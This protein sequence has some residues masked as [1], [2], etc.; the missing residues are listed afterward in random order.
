MRLISILL[1]LMTVCACDASDRKARGQAAWAWASVSAKATP[2]ETTKPALPKSE[3][4]A[5]CADALQEVNDLRKA[6]GL[7]PFQPDAKLT[8]AALACARERA[9]RGIHGHLPESDFK[10]LSSSVSTN[11]VAAGC[12]AL[13]PSWGWQSCCWDDVGPTHAGAAYV[14]GAD[15]LRYNHIF[16]RTGPETFQQ[17]SEQVTSQPVQS[18]SGSCASGSCGTGRERRG[19]FRGR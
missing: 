18:A 9:A 4:R 17:R 10:H 11:G 6:R 2:T 7:P 12:A 3:T 5:E 19:L 1:V 15:G 13:E 14:M 16:V 8:E